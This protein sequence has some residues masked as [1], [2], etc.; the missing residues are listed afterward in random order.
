MWCL[1]NWNCGEVRSIYIYFK[2]YF[3]SAIASGDDVNIMHFAPYLVLL[4]ILILV[5]KPAIT[6]TTSVGGRY[7]TSTTEYSRDN[8]NEAPMYYFLTGVGLLYAGYVCWYL[9]GDHHQVS[10]H[11]GPKP[12]FINELTDYSTTSA[13]SNSPNGAAAAH[14]QT[15]HK[16]SEHTHHAK[17][18]F[19]LWPNYAFSTVTA[20]CKAISTNSFKYNVFSTNCRYNIFISTKEMDFPPWR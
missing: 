9:F 15:T 12:V 14:H 11:Q 16:H 18:I 4:V 20:K 5:I 8:P 17:W 13:V 6:G 19:V 1:A 7:G 2:T 3:R 10:Q